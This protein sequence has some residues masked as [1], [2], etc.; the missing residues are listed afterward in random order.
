M[1][2][3]DFFCLL[4][5][6]TLLAG[7]AIA[8]GLRVDSAWARSSPPGARIAAVY[9]RIDNTGG[10]ADRLLT[11][12]SAMATSVEVHRTSNEE[13]IARMRKVSMLHIGANEIVS[14][15]PGGLHIMLFGLKKPLVAGKTFML[16]LG[17]EVSG[18]QKVIVKVREN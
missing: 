1:N 7:T 11:L 15:E 14:A 10:K 16:E 8:G 3:R 5:P 12:K 18:K 2:R 9:L 4:L 6:V 13:G 17:F